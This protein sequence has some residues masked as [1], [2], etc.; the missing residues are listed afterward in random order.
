MSVNY[1]KAYDLVHSG[2]TVGYI[3]RHHERSGLLAGC[4]YRAWLSCTGNVDE[5][6]IQSSSI[7]DM[8]GQLQ[9]RGYTERKCEGLERVTR[10]QK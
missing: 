9:A 4:R 3:E 6:L 2:Q 10:Y 8:R 7:R 1:R 5:F